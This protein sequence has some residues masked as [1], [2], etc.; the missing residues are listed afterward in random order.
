MPFLDA[1]PGKRFRGQA[2]LGYERGAG[3]SG[4]EG[5]LDRQGHPRFG[6]TRPQ[7]NCGKAGAAPGKELG[8]EE[9]FDQGFEAGNLGHAEEGPQ[10]AV[11]GE[12]AAHILPFRRDDAFP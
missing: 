5:G 12:V 6:R 3:T 7:W 10:L 2:G 9:L 11:N 8:I 4:D 1:G